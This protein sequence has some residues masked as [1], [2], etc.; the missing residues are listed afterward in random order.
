MATKYMGSQ[1]VAPMVLV[2]LFPIHSQGLSRVYFDSDSELNHQYVIYRV[3][4]STRALRECRKSGARLL[5]TKQS[6]GMH[7]RT[8]P[9]LN[10]N[11][12]IIARTSLK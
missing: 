3:Y 9:D 6:V 5:S 2:I 4:P 10:L 7:N 8:L 11:R 1:H 12:R